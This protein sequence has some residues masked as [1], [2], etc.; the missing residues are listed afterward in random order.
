MPK[1]P[2][3]RDTVPATVSKAPVQTSLG[4]EKVEEEVS[5]EEEAG[6]RTRPQVHQCLPVCWYLERAASLVAVTPITAEVSPSKAAA[7]SL[8][9]LLSLAALAVTATQW[10]LRRSSVNVLRVQK[11]TL[12]RAQHKQ[13]QQ[14]QPMQRR[15]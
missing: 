15:L 14:R 8:L 4:K 2:K 3:G 11:S 13:Q 1:L 6:G 7:Q 10:R 12:S 9:F 5:L